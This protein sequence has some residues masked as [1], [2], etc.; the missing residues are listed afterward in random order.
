[1]F[2]FRDTNGAGSNKSV[3]A[4]SDELQHMNNQR[5][6]VELDLEKRLLALEDILKDLKNSLGSLESVQELKEFLNNIEY[7]RLKLRDLEDLSLIDK[8][9]AVEVKEKL[10]DVISLQDETKQ[11][12][13]LVVA[14]LKNLDPNEGD[15]KKTLGGIKAM[16]IHIDQLD[17]LLRDVQVSA[18]KAADLE[19]LIS[20]VD[21]LDANKEIVKNDMQR[22]ISTLREQLEMHE[23]RLATLQAQIAQDVNIAPLKEQL[24]VHEKEIEVL[25]DHNRKLL[26]LVESKARKGEAHKS[27][28]TEKHADLS[29]KL[30]EKI[31]ASEKEMSEL[32]KTLADLKVALE[33]KSVPVSIDTTPFLKKDDAKVKQWDATL[34]KIAHM[35][36]QL[37]E[38]SRKGLTD[39]QQSQMKLVLQNELATALGQVYSY[40]DDVKDALDS[41]KASISK[42]IDDLHL[43]ITDIDP[44][45]QIESQNNRIDNLS[46]TLVDIS[47]KVS[48]SQSSMSADVASMKDAVATSQNKLAALTKRVDE[49]I[50]Q[51]TPEAVEQVK[52]TVNQE[53][54]DVLD[55]LTELHTSLRDESDQLRADI[56][57]KFAALQ[58]AVSKHVAF[59][60]VSHVEGKVAKLETQVQQYQY[61]T[62]QQYASQVDSLRRR[63]SE[64][65]ADVGK[66]RVSLS[67]VSKQEIDELHDKMHALDARISTQT[68]TLE[69]VH[70]MFQKGLSDVSRTMFGKISSENNNAKQEIEALHQRIDEL[71]NELADVSTQGIQPIAPGSPEAVPQSAIAALVSQQKKFGEWLKELQMQ[72]AKEVAELKA[73]IGA[74]IRPQ[75]STPSEPS[76]D[77]GK[78]MDSMRKEN[79]VLKKELDKIRDALMHVMQKDNEHPLVIE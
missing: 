54:A 40:A 53:L 56:D 52:E 77:I 19:P 50:E 34:Q 18:L 12:V 23:K 51:L 48:A 3:D 32:K 69:K 33:A 39:L 9:E 27:A 76:S 68:E 67:Q 65:E 15:M 22:L 6:L 2:N 8:L 28:E 4:L 46:Q 78:K 61:E 79:D 74:P 57:N 1:M 29:A 7:V 36:Q 41:Y 43:K 63:M 45:G 55:N 72:H 49:R 62:N 64:T 25:R 42:E 58:D 24:A 11:K 5:K 10:N 75:L 14:A 60:D 31:V 38:E 47:E 66:L 35:A 13:D 73:M 59:N 21:E 17:S 26:V 20:K 70:A 37:D 16:Q 30:T 44:K 71:Q